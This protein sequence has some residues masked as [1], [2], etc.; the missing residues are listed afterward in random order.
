MLSDVAVGFLNHLLFS[1]GWAPERLRAFSGQSVRIEIGA[2]GWPLRVTSDGGFA[3]GA[4]NTVATV[5]I[6][7]PQDALLLVLTDRPALVAAARISGSG[8]LAECLGF[9]FRN[10]QWDIE[11]D[12]SQ[13]VG[14]IAARRLL[15]GGKQ[16]LAWQSGQIVN[17]ALNFAEYVTEE[18]QML[19]RRQDVSAFC[20]EVGKAQEEL[21]RLEKRVVQLGA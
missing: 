5:T 15:A 20:S 18:D 10:L 2:F 9:V 16:W 14:D 12:L 13:W 17:L 1:E 21:V 6:S 19:A 4:K 11:S 8:E 3:V 7:F